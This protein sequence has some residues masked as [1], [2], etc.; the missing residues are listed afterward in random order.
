[1]I[2]SLWL[3]QLWIRLFGRPSRKTVPNKPLRR[4]V[5]LR[6]DVLEERLTPSTYIVNDASDTPGSSA[7]V[8]L[9]YAISQA[10][11]A[12][13][14]STIEFSPSLSGQTITLSQAGSNNTY[15]PTAFIISNA[16]I[17]IDGYNAPGLVISGD[18]SLRPFAVTN[19]GSL[20]LEYLTVEDGLAQGGAGGDA[21]QTSGNGGGGG[22]GAGLGGGVFVDAGGVFTAQGVTFTNNSAQ[23]GSGGSFSSGSLDNP[24][25]GGGGG[26]M[27]VDGQDYSAGG[28][29]G[30]NG[31]A[32]PGSFGSGGNAGT[33]AGSPGG[34]GGF[35]GGGGGGG[36]GSGGPNHNAGGAGGFGGG[37]GGGGD[38]DGGGGTKGGGGFGGGSGGNGDKSTG[39][40]GGGGGGMG[41]AIFSNAGTLTLVND[42][43]TGNTAAGGQGGKHASNGSGDGGAVFALNGNLMATFDTFSVNSAG[44]GTDVYVLSEGAGNQADAYFINDIL[45]SSNQNFVAYNF[46]GGIFPNM[47]GSEDNVV[48]GNDGLP[49]SAVISSKDPG[50]SSLGDYGG[51]TPTMTINDNSS[52]FGQGTP[53]T[54]YTTD[55]R[56]YTRPT[57]P[58]LG[59]FDPNATPP[60]T[61]TTASNATA[62]FSGTNQTVTLTA[63]VTSSAGTVNQGMVS[64]TLRQGSSEPLT[65]PVLGSVSD[66]MASVSYVLPAGTPAGSYAIDAVYNPSPEYAEFG[67]AED[68]N[69]YLTIQSATVTPTYI[70]TDASD[71]AGS[72]AHVTLPYA[73]NQA[74]STGGPSLIEFSRS[75]ASQTIT[76]TQASSDDT[77]GPTAF[78]ISN[79]NIT[80][81]GFNAPGLVISGNNSLRPFAVTRGSLTL[82]NLTVENGLAFGGD[83]GD[84]GTGGGGGGG[85]GLGGAVYND[86]GAFTAEGVTFVNNSAQGGNGGASGEGGNGSMTGGGGGGMG[87]SGQNGPNGG[88]GGGNGGTGGGN[89]Y[90]GGGPPGGGTGGYGGG[91]GGGKAQAAGNTGG[92]G[93]FGAGGGGAGIN[94]FYS[95]TGGGGGFGAGS[96]GSPS[97]PNYRKTADAGGGGGGAGL[98]GAVFSSDGGLTLFNNTFT[99]NS[100]TGGR[101]GRGRELIGDSGSNGSGD[102]GAVFALNGYLTATFDTFSGNTATQGTDVYVLSYGSGDQANAALINDILASLNQDF[103]SY[104]YD[105]GIAPNLSASTHDLVLGN[106]G[107]PSTA[108]QSTTNFEL[109]PLANNGGPTQTMAIDSNS[110]ASE[111]A[112]PVTGVST[113]QRGYTR[114]TGIP[115]SPPPSL[116][117]FDPNATP[118]PST[119]TNASNVTVS[120]SPSAQSL[121]LSATVSNPAGAA[122]EGVVTFIVRQGSSV[123]GSATSSTAFNNGQVS[124][125]YLLPGGLAAGRYSIEADYFDPQGHLAASSSTASLVVQAAATTSGGSSSAG[126]GPTSSDFAL[127]AVDEF[128][129]TLESVLALIENTM[130]ITDP[131]LDAAIAQLSAAI[132]NDPLFSTFEGHLAF[133]L[134][135]S[136]ALHVL[137][138]I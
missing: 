136:F 101:G 59:A 113:D 25:T 79:A 110:S 105:N 76:L 49:F 121:T 132:A 1:M 61:T 11:N 56:G 60:T 130:Q 119:T 102:G 67:Q 133:L 122:S 117:A 46:D 3:H 13:G 42:T 83:G 123:I 65:V 21:D 107:L 104:Q 66:G 91:G 18:N 69:H 9:P 57:N 22:G 6:L 53:Y 98:G 54:A 73:I 19:T 81:D 40:G 33:G 129:L 5:R 62:T 137:S 15:G 115:P 7:D 108:V 71:T 31:S 24:T 52:A 127:L 77:Y 48:T 37:G 126:V 134:G 41:G 89:E 32:K 103:V 95:T 47:M 112:V 92:G 20:T 116:G 85:A 35:G 4:R 8:T 51:P 99:G 125:D 75:L 128:E 27:G 120:F 70:V 14:D 30:T 90:D 80:I 138:G 118:P 78:V 34:A 43:F 87:V 28:G 36:G 26:G 84:S 38:K 16:N 100:A 12:G 131:S 64:F 63:D 45:A 82:E 97:G 94:F 23:G 10:L 74:L 39:G 111:Q 17:T 106:D 114:P 109:P 124:V 55:Q 58:S 135:D 68:L 88:Y 72:R 93:G 96:G 50:L 44:Q 29:G 2:A 86:G